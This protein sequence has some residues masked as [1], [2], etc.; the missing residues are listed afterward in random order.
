MVVSTRA[1][2]S[3]RDILTVSE[4]DTRCVRLSNSRSNAFEDGLI[5]I[6][7]V[8]YKAFRE[9]PTFHYN[10]LVEEIGIYD[11]HPTN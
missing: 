4:A 8:M 5:Q 9:L 7:L 11:D 1:S 3:R 10:P 2:N 6:A